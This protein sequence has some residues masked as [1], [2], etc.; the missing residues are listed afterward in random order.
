MLKDK[1]QQKL[2]VTFQNYVALTGDKQNY[3]QHK[4]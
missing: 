1:Q 2:Q 3:I 4:I